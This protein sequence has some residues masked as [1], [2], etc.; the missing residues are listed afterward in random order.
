MGVKEQLQNWMD[1]S[2]GRRKVKVEEL[3]LLGL[4]VVLVVVGGV[5]W[6]RVREPVEVE[7]MKVESEAGESIWVDVAGAVE[8]PGV[9]EIEEGSRIKDVLMEAG[10]LSSEADRGYVARYM[11]LA[12]K[13]EDGVKLYFPA[14]GDESYDQVAGAESQININ[15]ASKSQLDELWGVGEVRAE[16]IMEARPFTKVEELAEVVPSNVYERIKDEVRV[17]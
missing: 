11:N 16:A 12:T 8:E 4:G 5:W 6:S 2:L 15:S 17:Y 1:E 3:A 7:I 14:E 13:V 10:G 9:Y